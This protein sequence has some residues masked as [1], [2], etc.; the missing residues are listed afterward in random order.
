[1]ENDQHKE[2]QELL[3]HVTAEIHK[4]LADGWRVQLAG[5]ETPEIL[6][7]RAMGP[8]PFKIK[9][10]ALMT[11][12]QEAPSEQQVNLENFIAKLRITLEQAGKEHQLTGEETNIYPVLRHP[13]FLRRAKVTYV[14]REHTPETVIVYAL[15]LEQSYILITEEMLTKEG[16]SRDRLHDLAMANLEKLDT[17]A[18][19]DRVGENLFYFFSYDDSYSASRVLHP[20]L[21]KMMAQKCKGQMGIALPHQDVLVMA[22]LAD[23]KGAS[24]LSQIATDFSMR[25]NLPITP[26]PFMYEK[27]GTLEPYMVMRHTPSRHKYPS[28]GGKNKKR[29]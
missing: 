28:H 26:M 20:T 9:L 17:S 27:D 13:S 1:M 8:V 21:L 14:H 10:G 23:A 12:L 25:G 11:K 2:Y 16:W 15:D 7:N 24:V 19:E 29:T 4:A 3:N 6:I 5:G 18:H 22:D